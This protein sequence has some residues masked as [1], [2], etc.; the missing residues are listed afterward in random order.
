MPGAADWSRDRRSVIGSS[1]DFDAPTPMTGDD[2]S[3]EVE[4]ERFIARDNG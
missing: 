4:N 2:V 1:F 3:A